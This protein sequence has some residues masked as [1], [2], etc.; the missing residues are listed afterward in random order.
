[1]DGFR[2]IN[3]VLSEGEVLSKQAIIAISLAYLAEALQ[4][5]VLIFLKPKP[6]SPQLVLAPSYVINCTFVIANATLATLLY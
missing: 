2:R 4:F 3:K 1:M 6:D 5:A